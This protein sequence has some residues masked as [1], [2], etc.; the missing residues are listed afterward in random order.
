MKS[1]NPEQQK[2]IDHIL[3]ALLVLA[4]AGTGK[5]RVLTERVAKAIHNGIPAEKILCVTFTNRA[6]K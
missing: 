5:T 2:I 6:A 4:P 3:G 1:F